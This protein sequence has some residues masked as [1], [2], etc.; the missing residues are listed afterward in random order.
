MLWQAER[1]SHSLTHIAPDGR[2]NIVGTK[3]LSLKRSPQGATRRWLSSLAVGTIVGV[4]I[5]AII[6][7][8]AGLEEVWQQRRGVELTYLLAYAGTTVVTY[9]F[10][11][12]RFRLLLGVGGVMPKLYGIVSVHTLMLNLLPFSGGEVSYP[13][14]L[15]RYGISHGFMEGVPSIV[16]ARLQDALIYASFLLVALVWTGNVSVVAQWGIGA[17]PVTTLLVIPM[18]GAGAVLLYTRLG[19]RLPVIRHGKRLLL[20]IFSSFRETPRTVW[21]GA[22]LIT[23]AARFTSF[24]AVLFL[25]ESLGV[26]LPF[27]TVFLITSLYVFLPYLPINTPA[28]LGITEGYLLAFF[29]YAGIDRGVATAASVQV[30]LLQLMTAAALGA[31]GFILLQYLKR[32]GYGDSDHRKS[33]YSVAA[34]LEGSQQ[35]PGERAS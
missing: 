22:F 3:M 24:I 32:R 14:L 18:V 28:G 23:F 5:F 35:S 19:E 15:K 34:R 7:A 9:L 2:T 26:S 1:C 29:I 4:I 17:I 30:H 13:I 31:A 16:I 33:L 21:V 12:W 8:W 6:I 11:A 27:S 25:F 20:E 10:R